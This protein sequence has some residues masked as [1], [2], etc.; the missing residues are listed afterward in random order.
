MQ[1]DDIPDPYVKTYLLPDRSESN[2]RKT[3]VRLSSRHVRY[4]ILERG[5]LCVVSPPP[6]G[7]S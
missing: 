6:E 7:K 4:Q 3:K 2:K 1:G 5:F